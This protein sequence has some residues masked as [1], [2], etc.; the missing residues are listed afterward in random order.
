MLTGY[1]VT[2]EQTQSAQLSPRE[3]N[4]GGVRGGDGFET[5]TFVSAMTVP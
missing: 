4:G 1:L 3:G 5:V 2:T